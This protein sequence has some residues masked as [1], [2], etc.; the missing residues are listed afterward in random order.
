MAG[1]RGGMTGGPPQF[2]RIS[3]ATC[4]REAIAGLERNAAV[5]FPGRAYRAAMV[6]LPFVPR[7]LL[8]RRAARAAA[9]VRLG[10][11]ASAPPRPVSGGPRDGGGE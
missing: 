10:E 7:R 9:A 11:G 2:L 8:R 6:V 3:A 5:V 1:S 4:A